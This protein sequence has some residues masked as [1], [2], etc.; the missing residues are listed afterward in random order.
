M[1]DQVTAHIGQAENKGLGARHPGHARDRQ[2]FE[3]TVRCADQWRVAE[4]KGQT[5]PVAL[6][7]LA[8]TI[9]LFRTLSA[10]CVLKKF[11]E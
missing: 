8:A 3:D 7:V 9:G 4:T 1:I 2:G 10:Q 11:G 6:G 5:G